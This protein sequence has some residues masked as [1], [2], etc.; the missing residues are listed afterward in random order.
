MKTKNE[1]E[2]LNELIIITKKKRANELELIRDQL[3]EICESLRP[4]N[5]IKN[6]IQDLTNSSETKNNLANNAIGLGAGTF[7]KDLFM[8]SSNNFGKKILGTIIQF[9]VA[10]LVSKHFDA[11]K[12]IAT[13]LLKRIS[14]TDIVKKEN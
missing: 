8:G 3:H 5:L 10:N 1:T 11:I 4:C 6:A 2:L 13:N 9:S 14:E 12:L 7:V